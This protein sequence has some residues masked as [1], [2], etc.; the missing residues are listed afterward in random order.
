M[1]I[2]GPKEHGYEATLKAVQTS[3]EALGMEYLDLYLIHWPG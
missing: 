2:K 1:M 3:L